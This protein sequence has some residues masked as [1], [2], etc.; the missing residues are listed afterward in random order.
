MANDSHLMIAP[1]ITDWL[2]CFNTAGW[3][4]GRVCDQWKT[5]AIYSEGIPPEQA[6]D[7]NNQWKKTHPGSAGKLPQKQRWC[8]SL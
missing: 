8:D 6:E 5:S 1:K 3:V 4:S 2:Q 7:K